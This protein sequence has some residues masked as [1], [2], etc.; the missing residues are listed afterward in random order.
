MNVL[1]ESFSRVNLN[2]N[3]S[4]AKSLVITND[5]KKHTLELNGCLIEQV[6]AYNIDQK[7]AKWKFGHYR[8]NRKQGKRNGNEISKKH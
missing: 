2:V 3:V 4:K 1:N 7:R 5:K 6:E 8:Q